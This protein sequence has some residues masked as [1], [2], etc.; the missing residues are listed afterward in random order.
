MSRSRSP[1]QPLPPTHDDEAIPVLTERLGASA[2]D[3]PPLDFDTT[4][5]TITGMPDGDPLEESIEEVIDPDPAPP[6]APLPGKPAAAATASTGLPSLAQAPR[7]AG[8]APERA[9][10]LASAGLSAELAGEVA[11]RVRERLAP[12]MERVLSVFSAFVREAL[13]DELRSVL[14]DRPAGDEA[15]PR[16]R[17]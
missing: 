5:P 6:Q 14:G 10:A 2:V 4:I 1:F 11:A 15:A 8:A 7:P 9:P 3:M 17:K 12:E 13:E 16:G